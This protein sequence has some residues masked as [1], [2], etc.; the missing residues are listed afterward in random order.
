MPT[1]EQKM[2]GGDASEQDNNQFRITTHYPMGGDEVWCIKT[3][4]GEDCDDLGALL[5]LFDILKKYPAK[6]L[7][8]LLGANRNVN[9]QTSLSL[10][11]R[12]SYPLSPEVKERVFVVD[13]ADFVKQSY[14]IIKA[15]GEVIFD[16]LMIISPDN[17]S[18]SDTQHEWRKEGFPGLNATQTLIQGTWMTPN[19]HP[20]DGDRDGPDGYG[21]KNGVNMAGHL[22]YL[23][24]FIG[25]HE[26]WSSLTVCDTNKSSSCVADARQFKEIYNLH[27]DYAAQIVWN[28]LYQLVS[29]C[30]PNLPWAQG[31]V[32]EKKGQARNFNNLCG[33]YQAITGKD[34]KSLNIEMETHPQYE[35]SLKYVNDLVKKDYVKSECFDELLRNV[36][37]M[38]YG[39]TELFGEDFFSNCEDNNVYCNCDIETLQEMP[40]M[41]Q[42]YGTLMDIALK[43]NVSWIPPFYDLMAVVSF[44][45]PD[46]SSKYPIDSL[47]EVL[48]E[49]NNLTAHAG[50]FDGEVKVTGNQE[51]ETGN[52][53]AQQAIDNNTSW[54]DLLWKYRIPVGVGVVAAAVLIC[55]QGNPVEA[56][57][58][59][60]VS[61]TPSI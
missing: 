45:D 26:L 9:L 15:G 33:V 22:P 28:A 57:A 61:Y 59:S 39:L 47:I 31:L 44:F 7:V 58:E 40:I 6:K 10:L 50:N 52:N 41:R 11:N 4:I 20:T 13:N 54:L 55:R 12:F 38:N 35:R 36:F 53:P 27:Q 51:S 34:L 29:R 5:K 16:R 56:I 37:L 3:D 2:P 42:A 21:K 48:S 18:L 32:C 19:K 49:Q 43:G 1:G 23:N 60:L 17:A 14:Q 8:I 46:C 24:R 25:N 30:D